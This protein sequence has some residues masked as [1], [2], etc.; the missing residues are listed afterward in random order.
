MDSDDDLDPEVFEDDQDDQVDENDPDEQVDEDNQ[1][2]QV[3]VNQVT[4]GSC[5][6]AEYECKPYCTGYVMCLH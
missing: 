1:G 4:V 6:I 5:V 2:D 3:D